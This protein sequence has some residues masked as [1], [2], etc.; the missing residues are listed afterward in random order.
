VTN[1]IKIQLPLD[2]LPERIQ[3]EC[4]LREKVGLRLTGIA[5]VKEGDNSQALLLIFQ[6]N[7]DP[8]DS[9]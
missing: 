6:G 4:D 9:P 1:V 7:F 3:D 2:N 8:S 5:N